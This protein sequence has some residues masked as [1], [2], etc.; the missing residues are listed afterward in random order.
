S[1]LRM[2]GWTGLACSDV[3]DLSGA[4]R[5]RSAAAL[6]TQGHAARASDHRSGRIWTCGGGVMA[7]A[8]LALMPLSPLW[9]PLV[10]PGAEAVRPPALDLLVSWDDGP[11]SFTSRG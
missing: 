10:W 3:T 6:S 5:S 2:S 1:C 9:P 7:R 8:R 11:R 4:A